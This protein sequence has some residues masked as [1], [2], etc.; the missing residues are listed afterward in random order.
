MV[1]TVRSFPWTNIYVLENNP[2]NCA[3][4]LGAGSV[5]A[6]AA[7]LPS[8]LLVPPAYLSPGS[9][10]SRLRSSTSTAVTFLHLQSTSAFL[11]ECD[12]LK[13]AG[14][15]DVMHHM[16]S[17]PCEQSVE[18]I[19][20]LDLLASIFSCNLLADGRNWED[21]KCLKRNPQINVT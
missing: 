8:S 16:S 7:L 5:A 4:G 19:W 17:Q 10:G 15:T 12:K 11:R 21:T 3:W 1:C 6:W 9:A 2:A 14:Q 18:K 13:E 20:R